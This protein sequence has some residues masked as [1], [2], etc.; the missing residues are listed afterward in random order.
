M[1]QIFHC[2]LDWSFI[3][4]VKAKEILTG[5][6]QQ[7]SVLKSDIFVYDPYYASGQWAVNNNIGPNTE[8]CETPHCSG[9]FPDASKFTF[10]CW[11]R[12][13]R[14]ERNQVRRKVLTYERNETTVVVLG[15]HIIT[16]LDIVLKWRI[17]FGNDWGVIWRCKCNH[18]GEIGSGRISLVNRVSILK[19]VVLLSR[20]D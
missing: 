20:A 2:S 16:M 10:T 18:A 3:G 8:P 7:I 15:I 6:R 9:E 5:C 4:S 13:D 17:R 1:L 19:A 11:E 12:S 14:Y